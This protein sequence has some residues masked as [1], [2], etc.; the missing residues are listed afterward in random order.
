MK[1]A[2]E[3]KSLE[4]WERLLVE[5]RVKGGFHFHKNT[6]SVSSYWFAASIFISL[7]RS[8]SDRKVI[9]ISELIWKGNRNEMSLIVRFSGL[10]L[11]GNS[12]WHPFAQAQQVQLAVP[13]R[14]YPVEKH[15]HGHWT[16][17]KSLITFTFGETQIHVQSPL[18]LS[19]PMLSASSMSSGSLCPSVSGKRVARKPAWRMVV[20]W[21]I[22]SMTVTHYCC[23]DPHDE[24]R[25]RQPEDFGEVKKQSGDPANPCHQ[26]ADPH[27]LVPHSC[28]EQLGGVEVDNEEGDGSSELAHKRQNQL[29][30]GV[31][32]HCGPT[33]FT[34]K[35]CSPGSWTPC[36]RPQ[37]TQA[38]P[39]T[40]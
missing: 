5:F 1:A 17:W 13:Q 10:L 32:V 38:R 40:T 28:W 37:T 11:V 23:N 26:G 30:K 36:R 24:N 34:C 7:A 33:F 25:C 12:Q 16:L 4:Y 14:T 39:E 22:K 27:R 20:W 19:T 18:V 9:M 3:L 31:G 2:K 21:F 15:Q 8:F 29:W 6:F 35:A